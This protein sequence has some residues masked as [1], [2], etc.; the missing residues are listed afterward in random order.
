MIQQNRKTDAQIIEY[1][2]QVQKDG[3]EQSAADRLLKSELL[4]SLAKQK[5]N[6][7]GAGKGIIRIKSKHEIEVL[8]SNL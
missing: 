5:N 1:M 3:L 2:K 4:P 7:F 6:E 8:M